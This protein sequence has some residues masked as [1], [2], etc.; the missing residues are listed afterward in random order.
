MTKDEIIAGIEEQQDALEKLRIFL[1]LLRPEELFA[2]VFIH[3]V[4]GF[5]LTAVDYLT[6][7]LTEIKNRVRIS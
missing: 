4:M 6:V 1:E 5:L 2:Q 3:G 7:N